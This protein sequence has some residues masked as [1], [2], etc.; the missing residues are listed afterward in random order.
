[1]KEMSLENILMDV[2]RK[3]ILTGN[4]YDLVLQ[5]FKMIFYVDVICVCDYMSVFYLFCCFT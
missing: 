4:H 5:E 3:G 1:M 2:F